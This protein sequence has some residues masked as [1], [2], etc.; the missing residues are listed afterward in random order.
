MRCVGNH[1]ATADEVRRECARGLRPLAGHG[2]GV[3][4]MF[5]RVPVWR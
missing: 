2:F 4:I 3:L 1:Q 5:S